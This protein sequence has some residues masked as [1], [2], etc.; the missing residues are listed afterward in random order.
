MIVSIN[1]VGANWSDYFDIFIKEIKKNL[2]HY[3]CYQFFFTNYMFD[4]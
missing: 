4:F 3:I 2:S 1:N